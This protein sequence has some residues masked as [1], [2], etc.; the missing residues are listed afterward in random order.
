MN[1]LIVQS[2]RSG[3][4]ISGE[5][6]VIQRD[7]AE[8][9]KNNVN[10]S[11]KELNIPIKGP[12][13]IIR[14][15]SGLTWSFK[16]F[17]IIKKTI[18]KHKPDIIHFHSLFPY[19]S[20]SVLYAAKIK[21]LPIVQTLHN[22]R[23]VCLEGSFFRKGK[24]CYKC[25]NNLGFKGVI[26]GCSHGQIISFFVFLNNF[27][28]RRKIIKNP[29]DKY[30]AVSKFI[31]DVHV[32]AGFIEKDIVVKSPYNA[33]YGIKVPKIRP[34]EKSLGITFAGRISKAK[35]SEVLIE[36]IKNFNIQ[37]NIIGDGPEKN[38]IEKICIENDF[39]HVS[40]F[41]SIT[42]KETK[43]I[44]SKSFCIV[45]PSQCSEALS[46]T[47]IESISSFVPVVSS[48]IGGLGELIDETK[49][50]LTVD[51]RNPS[52]FIDSINLLIKSP[53]LYLRCIENCAKF[54]SSKKDNQFLID[55]YMSVSSEKSHD[56]CI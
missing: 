8:L 36:I 3:N 50:G 24:F 45:I 47:A 16:N 23:W 20:I 2:R 22:V 48:N 39:K 14:S 17:I 1:V 49:C 19:L 53:N 27:L 44:I 25:I 51:S 41:G 21:K 37:I 55:I 52:E 11:L 18:E 40:F 13:S 15:I 32:K 43:K 10:V 34:L 56:N 6:T 38:K 7:I 31:K 30:I 35:G 9:R 42:N 5:D 28:L 12:I 33:N 54:L 29:I 26:Y 4:L 46:M